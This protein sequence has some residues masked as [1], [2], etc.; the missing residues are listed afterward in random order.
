MGYNITKR[1]DADY[2]K[3][4]ITTTINPPT[5]ALRQYATMEDWHLVVVGDLKTPPFD[6]DDIT[7]LSPSEQESAYPELSTLIGW[8]SIQRRNLGFLWALEVGANLVATVDD[9]NVPL[10]DW[11]RSVTVGQET[12]AKLYTGA[13]VFDPLA[14]TNYPQ[15]WHRGFPIQLLRNRSYSQSSLVLVPD[16]EAAFWNGDPDVDAICRMEHA[17]D[18]T[19]DDSQFPFSFKG[20]SPFNS[21]N[22][23][24][25]REA[26]KKYCMIPHIGRMDDIWGGYYLQALGFK[27]L[28][29]KA[30]VFQD[31]NP[32]D[33]TVDFEKEVLGYTQTFHLID[34]LRTEGADS[35]HNFLPERSSKAFIEYLSV[36][37]HL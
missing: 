9:D 36:A 10:S 17:P 12:S 30:S 33:L 26:L 32:H 13:T 28:Y 21:Q 34:S 16:V 25:S 22:T 1:S 11:G 27:T 35:I 18:C 15:Y 20:F 24:M 7:Y 37:E 8:N 5:E 14:V 19:F 23:F 4:I 29:S 3:I 6:L 31:R 2:Q